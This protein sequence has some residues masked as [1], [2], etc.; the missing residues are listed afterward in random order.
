[1][2]KERKYKI[3]SVTGGAI[4]ILGMVLCCNRMV[5]I[6]SNK[7]VTGKITSIEEFQG[8]CRRVSGKYESCLKAK[9]GV[10]FPI[11]RAGKTASGT[12]E[13]EHLLSSIAPGTELKV[14]FKTRHPETVQ[15]A[16]ISSGW[17][18]PIGLLVLGSLILFV[19]AFSRKN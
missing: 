3:S 19:S 13:I 6:T 14:M 16:D 4:F 18:G 8:Q 7:I 12:I 1:M 2:D 9:A 10:E 15:I 11:D 5:E 17:K